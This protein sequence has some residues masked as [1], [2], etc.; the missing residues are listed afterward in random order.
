MNQNQIAFAEYWGTVASAVF[1]KT[2]RITQNAN[3]ADK[4]LDHQRS[5]LSM[6]IKEEINRTFFHTK[7]RPPATVWLEELKKTYPLE[8]SRLEGYM[9]NCAVSSRGHESLL[10]IAVGGTAA[11]AGATMRKKHP[12]AATLLLLSGVAV[13]G[14]TIASELSVDTATLQEEVKKQFEAWKA[15][16]LNI[17]ATCDDENSIRV[18]HEE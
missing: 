11:V 15:S 12:A 1:Y 6:C 17:L 2:P 8:A 4:I 7:M 14:C 18:E 13:A 9:K 10:T 5:E 16:L 3:F